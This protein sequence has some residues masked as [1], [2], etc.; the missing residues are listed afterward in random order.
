ML[1]SLD[2]LIGFSVIMLVVSMSVTLIIQWILNLLGMRGKKL[3]QGVIALLKQIDPDLLTT[4]RATE[5]AGRIL[6]HPMLAA[7]PGKLAEVVQ[8]EDLVKTILAVAAGAAAAQTAAAGAG[9]TVTTTAEAPARTPSDAE[10]ALVQALA[11]AGI[12]NPAATLDAVRMASMRMEAEKPELATHVREAIAVIQQAESQFVAR[13]NG[14]FDQTME[15]VSHSFSRYSRIWAIG[16]SL[17]LALVLQLDSFRMMNRLALDDTLRTALVQQAQAV[18]PPAAGSPPLDETT[19]QNLVQLRQLATDSLITWPTDWES[20]K[21]EMARSSIFGLLLTAALLSLGAPFWFNAL[22]DLLKL[23][24]M[25]ASTEDAQ[26]NQRE[27]S[28]PSA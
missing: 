16:I 9:A 23:R 5:L 18:A 3:V 26:R 7:E 4:E 25:L 20:W 12:P 14:T 6:G 21:Q 1:K 10:R 8:R 27:T 11:K 13:L 28:Q 17:V 2:I 22:G 24:P 15:R 19:R